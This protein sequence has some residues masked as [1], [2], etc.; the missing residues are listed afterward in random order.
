MIFRSL[1]K[2]TVLSLSWTTLAATSGYSETF[3]DAA[4]AAIQA[5]ATV[6]QPLGISSPEDNL[7][8]ES[9]WRAIELKSFSGDAPGAPALSIHRLLIRAPSLESVAVS[10]ESE[11][12]TTNNNSLAD[13]NKYRT[14]TAALPPS[15]PGAILVD[16]GDFH[17]SFVSSDTCYV[18]TL[19]Y[20]EN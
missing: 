11:S 13:W 4:S 14:T 10:I 3:P 18:I 20:T 17:D 8:I 1:V 19:I 5:T 6:V 16:L 2:I 9:P 15:Q 7:L 12:G